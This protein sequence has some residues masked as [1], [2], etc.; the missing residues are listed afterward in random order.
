MGGKL[1]WPRTQLVSHVVDA[2]C[3]TVASHVE[4]AVVA[5]EGK[6]HR[7]TLSLSSVEL[8]LLTDTVTEL[9]DTRSY[10]YYNRVLRAICCQPV[11]SSLICF[12]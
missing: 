9:T 6:C 8:D 10:Y 2:V 12:M 7:V 3:V 1:W 11:D 5:V 4:V